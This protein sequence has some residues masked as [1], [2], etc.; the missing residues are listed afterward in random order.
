LEY[1]VGRGT[2]AVHFQGFG[3]AR[4]ESR[5]RFEEALEIIVRAWTSERVTYNGRFY[6]VADI[7]VAPRPLQKPHPPIRIA[8]NS[9]ETAEF[10]G[11]KGYDVLVAS[12][13]N[14][15]PGFYEHI[16]AYRAALKTGARP[17]H[18]GDVAALF[19]VCPH[20][21]RAD[22]R[23]EAERSLL[24]YFRTIGEQAL[25]GGRGQYEG[26]Y[27][28]LEQVRERAAA[29]TYETVDETMAVYGPPEECIAR[30]NDVYQH[31][32][33]DQLVC[34]FNAG[35]LIPHRAVMATMERFAS[36]VMPAVRA[37]GAR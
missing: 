18:A 20:A 24:H 6:Q 2:I 27:A 14:P 22:A 10:A 16:R 30:I 5:E 34:W 21:S 32:A 25:L 4:D 23:A 8:A 28:Y 9:P 33:I 3:T 19:F 26:S 15:V 13:I 1:G 37:L 17:A 31:S 12:P 36:H 7:A 35:G 29:M 11:R